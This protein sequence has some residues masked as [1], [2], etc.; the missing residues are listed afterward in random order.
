MA[1][2]VAGS[3]AI[4]HLSKKDGGN[5]DPCTVGGGLGFGVYGLGFRP[6]GLG[7]RGFGV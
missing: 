2:M 3:S 6:L 1:Q 7:F 4:P 5:L